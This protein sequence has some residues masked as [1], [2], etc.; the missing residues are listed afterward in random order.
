MTDWEFISAGPCAPKVPHTTPYQ[1]L[2]TE[3]ITPITP[4]VKPEPKCQISKCLAF[5]D[6]VCATFNGEE[7]SFSNACF[8]N[9]YKCRTGEGKK[10][11]PVNGHFKN[12]EFVFN[13]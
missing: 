2:V 5:R 1:G 3:I 6:P 11:K 4:I 13:F 9:N 7:K 12:F 8:F 10:H